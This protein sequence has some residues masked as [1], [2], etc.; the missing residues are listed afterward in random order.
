MTLLCSNPPMASYTTQHK[1]QR[2]ALR[3]IRYRPLTQSICICCSSFPFFSRYLRSPLHHHLLLYTQNIA[4]DW[5]LSFNIITVKLNH[6]VA[7]INSSFF[8]MQISSHYTNYYNFFIY[9]TVYRN[10]SCFQF[11]AITNKCYQHL[12]IRLCVGICFHSL[13]MPGPYGRCVFKIL[14]NF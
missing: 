12:F 9:S 7:Y 2:V 4:F 5:L 13:R 1:V 14:G 11:L 8:S 3:F 6:T 10:V